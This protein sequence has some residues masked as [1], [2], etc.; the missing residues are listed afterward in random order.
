MKSSKAI[1]KVSSLCNRINAY[2]S[3]E[4]SPSLDL[5]IEKLYQRAADIINAQIDK[6][7][8]IKLG[9]LRNLMFQVEDIIKEQADSSSY[10]YI[11]YQG[12]HDCLE[13][14][15]KELDK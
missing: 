15:I 4:W 1:K 6:S 14:L 5:E 11:L 8:T 12:W 7:V 9:D 13:Y 3:L 10:G 2:E